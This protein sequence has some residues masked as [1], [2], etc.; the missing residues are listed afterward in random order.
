MPSGQAVLSHSSER[1]PS[2][3][4]VLSHSSER[5]PSGQAVLSHS[6]ERVVFLEPNTEDVA[7]S[8]HFLSMLCTLGLG[9]CH[10]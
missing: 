7:W 1:V 10:T 9:C 8:A 5:V 6:S 3:Q 4:A 2:G